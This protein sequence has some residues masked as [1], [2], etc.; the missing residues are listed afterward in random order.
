MSP[1]WKPSA[2]REEVAQLVEKKFDA[3]DMGGIP[4]KQW[5]R[6][7]RSS[8]DIATTAYAHTHRDVQVH[9]TVFTTLTISI[10]DLDVQSACLEEFAP[11][12][13]RGER[14]AHPVL[15]H[16]VQNLL[17]ASK[18]FAPYVVAEITA[19]TVQFVSATALDAQMETTPMHEGGSL[20]YIQYKRER[21]GLAEA[22][23]CFIWEKR[24]F[25]DPSE[26]IQTI[27]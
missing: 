27:P 26:F 4:A 2:E 25:P 5:K 1:E 17:D 13:L 18:Y 3:L 24:C 9:V 23:S 21:N 14:Q 7:M 15:D 19:S 11:R 8:L 12:M 20:P 10:D 16:L 6:H 22:Y